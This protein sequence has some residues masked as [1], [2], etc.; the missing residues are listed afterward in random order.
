MRRQEAAWMPK[1]FLAVKLHTLCQR[2][3][4]AYAELDFRG[5]VQDNASPPGDVA[6]SRAVSLPKMLARARS[7]MAEFARY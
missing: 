4:Q 1:S 5:L 7:E 3:G 6:D 2:L